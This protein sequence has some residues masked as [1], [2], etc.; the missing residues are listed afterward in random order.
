MQAIAKIRQKTNCFGGCPSAHDTRN[1]LVVYLRQCPSDYKRKLKL[2][3]VAGT[4]EKW[5]FQQTHTFSTQR[6][7][8]MLTTFFRSTILCPEICFR[9]KDSGSQ[10]TQT[11]L[12]SVQNGTGRKF[13]LKKKKD[14]KFLISSVF[15]KVW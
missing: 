6:G 9:I 3:Y 15:A 12:D 5:I 11:D 13:K 10:D 7:Y 8:M 2:S 1:V 4:Q 14:G